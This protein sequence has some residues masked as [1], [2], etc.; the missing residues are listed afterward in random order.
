M[1]YDKGTMNIDMQFT[2]VVVVVV[3]EHA[4]LYIRQVS[5]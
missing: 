1:G 2:T 4:N 5:P 3:F